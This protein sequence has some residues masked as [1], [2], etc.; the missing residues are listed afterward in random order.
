MIGSR[1][2]KWTT[3]NFS[4]EDFAIGG[5]WSNDGTQHGNFYADD[6]TIIVGKCLFTSSFNYNDKCY[7]SDYIKYY[8]YNNIKI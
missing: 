4:F 2:S 7:I 3:G 8:L 6:I 1:K 5:L